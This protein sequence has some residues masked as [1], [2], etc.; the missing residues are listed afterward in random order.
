VRP[1]LAGFH[2]Y[3]SWPAGADWTGVWD[4]TV[5]GVASYSQAQIGDRPRLISEFGAADRREPADEPSRLYP[6]LY[7]H[8]IWA[9]VFSGQAGTPM[10]WDDGKEFGELC[11]RARKGIFDRDHYPIDH[12]GQ[13][14]ALR[15]FLGELRPDALR[16]CGAKDAP[17]SC[18][19]QGSL[20]AFAL[21]STGDAPGVHGWLFAPGNDAR[22]SLRG[23]PAGTYLLEWFDPWTGR[24]IESPVPQRVEVG[25]AGAIEIDAAAALAVLR[26]NAEPFPTRSRLARGSDVAFRLV[27]R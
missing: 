7:H 17:V 23:L 22:F 3:P 11:P 9:A 8:A 19:P 13:M 18:I 6:T 16:P 20:R 10:D 12:V 5:N 2:W 27:M 26:A 15:R 14:K 4:Y 24:A 25:E 1:D 21:C